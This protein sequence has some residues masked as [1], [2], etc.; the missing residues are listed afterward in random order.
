MTAICTKCLNKF[1]ILFYILLTYFSKKVETL[2][3]ISSSQVSG[4]LQQVEKALNSRAFPAIA[5]FKDFLKEKEKMATE[6]D[7]VHAL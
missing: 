4:L 5:K 2:S 6:E 1:K 7:G 3:G